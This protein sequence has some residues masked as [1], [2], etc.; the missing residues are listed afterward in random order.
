MPSKELDTY[1][2]NNEL[3]IVFIGDSHVQCAIQDSLFRNAKNLAIDSESTYFSYFKIKKLTEENPNLKKI[4]LGF[5]CHNI[6]S[7]YDEFIYGKYSKNIMPR[8]F[9]LLPISEKPKYLPNDFQFFYKDYLRIKLNGT[10]SGYKNQF[11]KTF[12]V[13]SSMEKRIKS[14]YFNTAGDVLAFSE[15]NIQY[16][17]KIQDLLTNQDIRLVLLDIPVHPYYE[18]RIPKKYKQKYDEIIERNQ[19]TRLSFEEII[20]DGTYFINDG[21]HL[22][23]KGARKFSSFLIKRI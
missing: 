17:H 16:L 6:S 22:S 23:E 10:K 13:I 8:Y 9:D 5:S 20:F 1:K 2:L 18:K 4:Y 12:A 11:T 3:E 21:D 15:L 7:F 14:Q 19:F